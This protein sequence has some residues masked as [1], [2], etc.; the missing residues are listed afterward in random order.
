MCHQTSIWNI[1]LA[2]ITSGCLI[3]CVFVKNS[4]LFSFSFL[5]CGYK[6]STLFGAEAHYSL[7]HKVKGSVF[8]TYMCKPQHSQVIRKLWIA[9]AVT[10]VVLFRWRIWPLPWTASVP[11]S[12]TWR[13]SSASLTRSWQMPRLSQRGNARLAWSSVTVVQ[14]SSASVSDSAQM[15]W[16]GLMP[17]GCVCLSLFLVQKS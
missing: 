4:G 1:S 17:M 12:A 2:H 10:C 15:C 9:I 13:R 16:L 14:L 3:V 8:S 7:R 5:G 6:L 11:T